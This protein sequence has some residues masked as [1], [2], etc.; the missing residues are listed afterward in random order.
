MVLLNRF[1]AKWNSKIRARFEAASDSGDREQAARL[2]REAR[3]KLSVSVVDYGCLHRL[4]LTELNEF[5]RLAISPGR[6]YMV[7]V[8]VSGAN[9][10]IGQQPVL[11]GQVIC[12]PQPDAPQLVAQV[13]RLPRTDLMQFVVLNF[14]GPQ[15]QFEKW[16]TRQRATLLATRFKLIIDTLRVLKA[17]NPA[18]A[19]ID[20]DDSEATERFFSSSTDEPDSFVSQA[21]QTWRV[22]S[23]PKICNVD[24]FTRSADPAQVMPQVWLMTRTCS[25]VLLSLKHSQ[26]LARFSIHAHHLFV[27]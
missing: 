22:I 1:V 14:L 11:Q 26:L 19:H 3:P 7:V 13:T 18:F 17:V 16:S 25:F 4:G 10:Q 12:F 23:D 6:P 8:N 2:L 24:V 5:E 27:C 15:R 20:I 21:N 9:A